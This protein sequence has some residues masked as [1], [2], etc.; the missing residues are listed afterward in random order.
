MRENT[1]LIILD[2]MMPG[3]SGIDV[4][5]EIRKK[6]NIPIIVVSAKAEDFDKIKGLSVETDDYL[7]KP[8][9]PLE[10]MARVEA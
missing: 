9:N 5:L 8:F 1:V 10:L 7:T 3:M 2:M 6:S 4:C